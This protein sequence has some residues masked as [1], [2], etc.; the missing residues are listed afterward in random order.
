MDK[1]VF[2]AED[3][4][5]YSRKEQNCDK[6]VHKKSAGRRLYKRPNKSKRIY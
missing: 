4:C 1:E 5:G 3:I 6:A 2:G